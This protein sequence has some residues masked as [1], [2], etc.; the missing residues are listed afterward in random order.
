MPER[1]I[2]HDDVGVV[3]NVLFAS[4]TQYEVDF[5]RAGHDFPVHCVLEE[6]EIRVVENPMFHL[7]PDPNSG[8]A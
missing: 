8:A 1:Q 4:S 6:N 3:V 7:R 2:Y 5:H